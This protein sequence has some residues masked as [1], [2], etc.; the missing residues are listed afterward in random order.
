[1]TQLSPIVTAV[2]V[3]NIY[4]NY[5]AEGRSSDQGLTKCPETLV[6]K[7]E[8]FQIFIDFFQISFTPS[9]LVSEM[10]T[11]RHGLFFFLKERKRK[12]STAKKIRDKG[13]K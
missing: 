4:V 1:M 5:L 2:A 6:Q 11:C 12:T 13:T 7:G 10:M 3:T 8:R 9:T